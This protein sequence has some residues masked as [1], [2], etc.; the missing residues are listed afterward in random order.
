[1]IDI[2][3]THRISA[4][5]SGRRLDTTLYYFTSQQMSWHPLLYTLFTFLQGIYPCV[6]QPCSEEGPEG[7]PT[8][9][10]SSCSRLFFHVCHPLC[11]PLISSICPLSPTSSSGTLPQFSPT[12]PHLSLSFKFLKSI[13]INLLYL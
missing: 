1:M 3:S 5:I 2:L 6:S 4:K 7:K 13:L 9:V 11:C 8:C 10:Y 12:S